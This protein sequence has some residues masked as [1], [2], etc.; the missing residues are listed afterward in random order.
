MTFL[1]KIICLAMVSVFGIYSAFASDSDV[2]LPSSSEEG[3]DTSTPIVD[4]QLPEAAELPRVPFQ[5]RDYGKA[6]EVLCRFSPGKDWI[7]D[8][9]LLE[10]SVRPFIPFPS[11]VPTSQLIPQ[12]VCRLLG[13]FLPGVSKVRNLVLITG[14]MY[15][16]KSSLLAQIAEEFIED[17]ME[18]VVFTSSLNQEHGNGRINSRSGGSVTA[19]NFDGVD[20]VDASQT[21]RGHLSENPRT[22]IIMDEIQFLSVIDAIDLVHLAREY[23]FARFLLGGL[24][25]AFTLQHWPSTAVLSIYGLSFSVCA[26]CSNCGGQN[27]S[28]TARIEDEK[29]TVSGEAICPNSTFRPLCHYCYETQCKRDCGRDAWRRIK[30]KEHRWELV[31]RKLEALASGEQDDM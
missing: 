8:Q 11:F 25:S 18:V 9:I 17:G 23:E 28:Y 6:A 5:E 1:R 22:A 29:M 14:S 12:R 24:G 15:G 16:G 2:P 4:L 7:D 31:V 30:S 10:K 3:R 13:G 21:I 19:L 26:T 27:A 20:G